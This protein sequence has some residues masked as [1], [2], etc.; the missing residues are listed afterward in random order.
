MAA[1]PGTGND[2]H[3]VLWTKLFTKACFR[4]KELY[5]LVYTSEQNLLA[6]R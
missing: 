2:Q 1:Y 6:I 4:E 5:N 3:E